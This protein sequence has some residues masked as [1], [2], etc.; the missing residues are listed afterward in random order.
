MTLG[1]NRST[2]MFIRSENQALLFSPEFKKKKRRYNLKG[3]S[4]HNSS[5]TCVAN[6]SVHRDLLPTTAKTLKGGSSR[7]HD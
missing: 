6:V 1:K 2:E 3:Y 4:G 5:R 7:Q